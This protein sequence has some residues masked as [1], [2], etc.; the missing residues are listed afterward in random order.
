[1]VTGMI[2]RGP[3][4]R[5]VWT[6]TADDHLDHHPEEGRRVEWRD[7]RAGWLRVERQVTVPFSAVG[8][9]LFLVRTY[10][11]PFASLADDERRVL[12]TAIERMPTAIADY[13]RVSPE[14]RRIVRR[15]LTPPCRA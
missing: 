11:Y 5:F 8:A 14:A 2:E 15:L 7:A 3:Y 4:V 1:M 10:V 12:A 9:S 13:K 6:V